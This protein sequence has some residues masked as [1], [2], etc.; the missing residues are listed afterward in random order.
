VVDDIWYP[1]KYDTAL[2]KYCSCLPCVD[3]SYVV[4]PNIVTDFKD[5]NPE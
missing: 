2:Q 3:P 1:P 4:D 5:M